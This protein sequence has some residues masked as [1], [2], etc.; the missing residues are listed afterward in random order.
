MAGGRGWCPALSAF[1]RWQV[2]TVEDEVQQRLRL[3]QS[4]QVE[5]LGEKERSELRKRKLLTEL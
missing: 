1:P 5:K 2:D 4:G 3:V